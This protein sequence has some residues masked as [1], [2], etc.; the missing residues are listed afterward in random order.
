MDGLG[1][2]SVAMR[3]SCTIENEQRSDRLNVDEGM[4]CCDGLVL[5]LDPMS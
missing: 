3:G 4:I 2:G 1:W 5:R